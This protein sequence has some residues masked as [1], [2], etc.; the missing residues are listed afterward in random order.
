MNHSIRPT[1]GALDGTDLTGAHFALD[2]FELEGRLLGRSFALQD[3]FAATYSDRTATFVFFIGERHF[4]TLTAFVPGPE[5]ADYQFTSA[6]PTQIL[7]TLAPVVAAAI[8]SPEHCG[9]EPPAAAAQ[10]RPIGVAVVDAAA[11][12]PAPRRASP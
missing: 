4:G 10:P 8:T 5:A 11:G 6:L 12:G 3:A 1:G 2:V 7:K 9:A